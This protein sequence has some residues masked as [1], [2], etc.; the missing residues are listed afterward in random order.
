MTTRASQNGT[1]AAEMEFE[2][3]H[4]SNPELEEEWELHEGHPYSNPYS[5]P[6]FEEEW[7]TPEGHPYSNPE[8]EWEMHEGHP[9]SNPELEE[10]WETPEGHPY[11]NPEMEWEMH[12]GHPYSNPELEEEWETPEGHPYS[13]PEMEWEMHEGHPYSN[14][15]SNPEMEWEMHEGHPYSNPYSNPEMEWEMH[16][17]HLYSNPYSNPEMEWEMHE[18][19]PYSNPEMEDEADRFIPIIAKAATRLLPKAIRVGRNLISGMRQRPGSRRRAGGAGGRNQQIAGLFHQLG[20][21]FAQG[22]YEAATH[23]AQLFGA[24]EFETEVTANEIAHQAALSE[25]MAAEAAH[26]ESASEAQA[27]MGATLPISM[28]VMGGTIG[29]RRQTPTL[30]RVNAQ[31]VLK[32][33]RQGVAGRQL[34]RILPSVQRR[35]IASLKRIEQTGQPIT[36]AIAAKVMTGQAARV[37]TSPHICRRALTRN[38]I[39]RQQ[40]V[41]PPRVTSHPSMRVPGGR[42]VYRPGV[43]RPTRPVYRRPMGGPVRPAPRPFVRG[44]ARPVYRR[45]MSGPVRPRP[46]VTGRPVPRARQHVRR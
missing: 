42:R 13:N 12:E 14:P 5:N 7:E 33:R 27:L 11:S 24:N 17:G 25:V 36:P 16:E 10:E 9:Y 40:T 15:Y 34:T 6:E 38:M 3:A 4:Y 21:I 20:R 2:A 41:A 18:G 30:L 44:P 39:V 29:I 19:H 1:G 46:G 37:L 22:E 32:L 43:I 23:E 28:R 31:L 35:A 8:M 26:T 45:P